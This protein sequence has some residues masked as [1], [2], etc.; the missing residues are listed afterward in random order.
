[1][2]EINF[3]NKRNLFIAL[4]RVGNCLDKSHEVLAMPSL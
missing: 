1:M 3:A 2:L 4:R